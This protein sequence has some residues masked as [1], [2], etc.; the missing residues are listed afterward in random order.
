MGALLMLTSLD[1]QLASW[2]HTRL[3][4]SSGPMLQALSF[5]G[6]GTLMFI[7]L[8][9]GVLV[10]LRR[11]HWHALLTLILTVPCGILSGEA[12]KLI[13]Q[14]QR[15]Y[16]SGPFVDWSGY[17]FPS[18]HAISATLFYGILTMWLC[19]IVQARHWR[20]GIAVGAVLVTLLVSF[21]RV[22][23]GAH[24]LSDVVAGIVFGMI[25]LI[26]CTRGMGIVRNRRLLDCADAQ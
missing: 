8:V 13:V 1:H 7:T 9:A 18:G 24:Y 26:V 10:L 4:D 2:F 19:P 15:P 6:G 3:D 23:L 20:V 21:S 25:W 17:S 11:R 12:I 5:A 14:R 22:A 16:L